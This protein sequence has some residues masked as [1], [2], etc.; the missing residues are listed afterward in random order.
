MAGCPRRGQNCP[1]HPN[2]SATPPGSTR[3]HSRRCAQCTFRFSGIFAI[4]L[5]ADL[6]TAHVRRDASQSLT[7]L[8]RH[9]V[10]SSSHPAH[11]PPRSPKS[12]T[13]RLAGRRARRHRA[14]PQYTLRRSSRYR[15]DAG[16][17]RATPTKSSDFARPSTFP[18]NHHSCP[19]RN[20]T[21]ACERSPSSAD[22]IR[23]LMWAIDTRRIPR[24]PRPPS[25]A[26]GKVTTSLLPRPAIGALGCVRLQSCAWLSHRQRPPD[27]RDS[28]LPRPRPSALVNKG[29][30]RMLIPATGAG[31]ALPTFLLAPPCG[32][33]AL[34][35]LRGFQ[36][37]HADVNGL[38]S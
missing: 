18:F 6:Q 9:G 38:S 13:N 17:R 19:S 25:L 5:T 12:P 33:E 29:A 32:L 28:F 14:P 7:W 2:L 31:V 34:L 27:V 11:Q 22:G 36:P 21:P 23:A 20:S 1:R 37:C 35:H 16:A 10:K 24:P 3:H 15:V 4:L 26:S 8:R 30:M